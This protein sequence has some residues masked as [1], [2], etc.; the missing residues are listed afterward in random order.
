MR[1]IDIWANQV[2]ELE[3][4]IDMSEYAQTPSMQI[5]L[6]DYSRLTPNSLIQKMQDCIKK[7]DRDFHFKFIDMKTGKTTRNVCLKIEVDNV[8]EE[9]KMFYD[10]K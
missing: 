10:F 6:S 4:G 3:H 7:Y 9:V 8:A 2:N 1:D 5:S